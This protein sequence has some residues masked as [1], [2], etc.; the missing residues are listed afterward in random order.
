MSILFFDTETTGFVSKNLAHNDP[1]QAKCVQLAGILTDDSGD[2]IN[3]FNC[4][5]QPNGWTVPPFVAEIH[6]IT[7]EK[8]QKYGV[9]AEL[10]FKLF[11]HIADMASLCVGHNYDFDHSM[12]EIE[13]L[14][15]PVFQWRPIAK[16][17]TMKSATAYCGLTKANGSPKWPKLQEVH[18]KLF[19]CSF[20]DAHDAMADVRAT[21][22][23]YFA[24]KKLGLV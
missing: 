21:M 3:E 24:M 18:N 16:C 13:S 20:D 11:N 12:L 9:P 7:T 17:C 23:C 2:T 19:G 10:A 4:I 8:A 15:Y 1:K 14:N 22:K 6:G 5:I